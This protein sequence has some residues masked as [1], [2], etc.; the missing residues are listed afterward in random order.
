MADSDL[1]EVLAQGVPAWNRWMDEHPDIRP[2]FSGAELQGV[3]LKE[4]NLSGADLSGADLSDADLTAADLHDSDL[5]NA[6]FKG[7]KLIDAD[8]S[9]SFGPVVD[10]S[11][12]V[13]RGASFGESKF[14][15]MICDDAELTSADGEWSLFPNASFKGARLNKANFSHCYFAGSDF[16]GANLRGS[17]FY[18]SNLSSAKFVRADVRD[19][20]LSRADLAYTDFTEANLQ[21]AHLEQATLMETV[22]QGAKMSGSYVYGIAVW[23]LIGE[24][25][26]QLNLVIRPPERDDAPAIIIDD[27]EI[28][29]FIYLL[30]NHKKLGGV[31]TSIAE[32]GVLLLGPFENGGLQ[33]LEA[34]AARL[35]AAPLNYLPIIFDFQ[36]PPDRSYTETVK[37]LVGLSRFVI[38]DLSGPS[39]PKE[40]EATVPDFKVPFILIIEK[41]KKYPSMNDDFLENKWVLDPPVR[42]ASEKEL[43]ETLAD[44]PIA[45]AEK[46]YKSRAKT[47]KQIYERRNK[48][49]DS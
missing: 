5:S 22:L 28:A 7:A 42:F 48:S 43:L 27:L 13:L 8:F 31:M 46:K 17:N 4:I 33:R 21:S 30:T 32:R 37:V 49:A 2:N 11:R 24:P 25:A 15:G 1:L 38:A 16:T 12:A 3:A 26:S 45:W 14:A 47:L 9:R 35:R 40:L 29:Q 20:Y 10:F 6:I 34:I 41:G 18:Q 23:D 36:P 44:R 19:A 39:V